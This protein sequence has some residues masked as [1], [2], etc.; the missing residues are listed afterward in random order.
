M[1]ELSSEEIEMC[2]QLAHRNHALPFIAHALQLNDDVFMEM[3]KSNHQ[4]IKTIIDSEYIQLEIDINDGL[5]TAVKLGDVEAIKISQKLIFKRK[6]INEK[7]T[8]A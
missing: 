2:K 8:Q 4:Q 5:M 1:R 6:T 3:Y 7:S